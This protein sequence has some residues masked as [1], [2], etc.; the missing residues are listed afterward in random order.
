MAVTHDCR[1][2]RN[3]L[4]MRIKMRYN[5]DK[6][7]DRRTT[8]SL[9]WNVA[10]NELPMWVAD[11]D[12][13]TAPEIAQAIMNRAS[14]GVFGYADITEEWYEAYIGWWQRRHNFEIKKEWMI[15]STGVVATIS[16]VVRKLTT[17]A[18]NVVILTPVY[19]IFYNSILNNGRNVLECELQY[20]RAD[21]HEYTID[22]EDLEEKLSNPQT[23]LM[24]FC[25]P[26][27]PV[28]KIW[29]RETLQRVGMLC[30]KH[31]VI[32]LSDEIHCDLTSPDKE[33]IPFAAV[34]EE[35]ADI[36]ITCI[37]PTKTFNLAGINSS[38]VIVRN[39]TLRHKVWRG[40]NTDE[41]GE[42]NAFAVDATVAAFTKGDMWLDELRTYIFENRRIV[43]EFLE[44]EI[45]ELHLVEGEAT[46]LLWM[47]CGKLTEK[48]INQKNL[49]ARELAGYIREQ[50]GLY[51]SDGV[52]YGKGGENFLRLN[53]ACPRE[54]LRDGLE[55]L[56]KGIALYKESINAI[57]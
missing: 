17:P 47:D 54:V 51:L 9:K 25:N 49:S 45:K 28:G 33:Y 27:N 55:R 42:P 48:N 39:K 6:M 43:R 40:I 3:G 1:Q 16:S 53:I 26:H 11:M 7:I 24:I 8:N 50:T 32:L 18:E 57:Q 46:Y 20:N 10:E 38:A 35:I 56:S 29:D 37:A 5:F 12:F 13:E 22:F 36:C 21:K 4:E 34:S 2:N 52:Q 15:F 23:S 19:N 31:D 30:V 14:H 41:V 44:N